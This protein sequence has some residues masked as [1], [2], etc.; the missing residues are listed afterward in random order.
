MPNVVIDASSVIGAAIK[1][2]S[3]PERALLMA[4]AFDT[5]CLSQS[6]LDEIADVMNRPKLARFI[7]EDRRIA[8][9]GLLQLHG[10]MFDVTE[11]V[12]DCRDAKDNR[13]LELALAC[14]ADVIVSSD[15]DLLVLHPWRGVPILCPADYLLRLAQRSA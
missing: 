10:R 6:V 8:I 13:Y 4:R 11:R 9:L 12:S 1:R 3:V 15:D 7:T 5:I 14:G 2:D